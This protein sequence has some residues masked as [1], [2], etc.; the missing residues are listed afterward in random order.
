MDLDVVLNE[1]SIKATAEDIQTA[2]LWMLNLVRTIKTAVQAGARRV[3][4]SCIDLNS[5]LLST[6]YPIARWRNDPKV[7]LEL[8]RYFRV[9]TTH[10]PPLKDQPALERD[11]SLNDFFFMGESALGLGIAFLLESL[12]VSFMSESRW[13]RTKI[14]EIEMQ[15]LQDD[16]SMI[17]DKI[18]VYHA[19]QPKHIEENSEWIRERLRRG[20]QSGEDLWSRRGEL[21][22]SLA[23]CEGVR[24]IIVTLLSGDPLLRQVAKRLFEIEKCCRGWITGAFDTTWLPFKV[25]GEHE[26]TLKKYEK[27]RTFFCPGEG[28]ITF[29]LHGRITPGAWRIYFEPGAKSGTMYIG[30]IGPKLPSVDYPT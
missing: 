29:K 13:N 8:R 10:Y 7:D 30:Y 14:E 23:F 4:R 27:E 6:N 12:S 19:S 28:K 21:F 20:I 22:P 2:Q 11:I 24:K 18:G 17:A 3:L 15:F 9:L 16:G 26:T 25:T 5:T 1:L